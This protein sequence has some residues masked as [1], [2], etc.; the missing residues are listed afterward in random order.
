MKYGDRI[1]TADRGKF[2]LKENTDGDEL[3]I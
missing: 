1:Y 3:W 2:T